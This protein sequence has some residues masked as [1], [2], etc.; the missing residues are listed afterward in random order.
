[1]NRV[2]PVDWDD[3]PD[4]HEFFAPVVARMGF[5]PTSQLTM[6]RRPKLLRAW[7][8]LASAVFD[9]EAKT[10]MQL[11]NLVALMASASAGCQYCMAH[12]GANA[13]RSG[14]DA[15]KIAAIW[16]YEESPL[17]SAAER[18]ALEFARAASVVP[19]AAGE[20][21]FDELRKHFDD[22]EIVE[23]MG[24]IAAFGFLNRWN[25]TMATGL[26]AEPAEFAQQVLGAGGWDG[27]KHLDVNPGDATE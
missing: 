3:I 16:E 15:E 13:K 10:T 24:V 11:R 18:A 17:F 20:H 23:L 12:T 14:V 27:R 21:H 6:A 4:L 9:A 25:D 26:E 8:A 2:E 5:V 7:I 1:M 22:D 19:N